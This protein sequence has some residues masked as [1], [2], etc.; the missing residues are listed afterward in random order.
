[1]PLQE[2]EQA[3]FPAAYLQEN[4]DPVLA[5]LSPPPPTIQLPAEV[6]PNAQSTINQ[7]S[8]TPTG[9]Q[10]THTPQPATTQHVTQSLHQTEQHP[11]Q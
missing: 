6:P 10:Q 4:F 9:N 11:T 8:Q 7:S 2:P 5:S 1:M 3:L